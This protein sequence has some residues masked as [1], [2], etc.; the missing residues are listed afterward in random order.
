MALFTFTKATV[1]PRTQTHAHGGGLV[2][3]SASQRGVI[4]QFQPAGGP[5]V[6]LANENGQSPVN[7]GQF[8]LAAGDIIMS[9]GDHAFG[10]DNADIIVDIT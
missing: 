1:S 6:G 4:Y 5:I 7:K 9:V 8:E 3:I 2:Q 10:G